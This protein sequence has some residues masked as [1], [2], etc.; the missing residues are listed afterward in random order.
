[1]L[2]SDNFLF[3]TITLKN[4]P[5]PSVTK[6]KLISYLSKW[7]FNGEEKFLNLKFFSTFYKS[8]PYA[9]YITLTTIYYHQENITPVFKIFKQVILF[10]SQSKNSNPNL[11]GSKAHWH[12]FIYIMAL[13]SDKTRYVAFYTILVFLKNV[14]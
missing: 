1:M 12:H 3:N 11:S 8:K 5:N 7:I 4:L 2:S 10:R 14:H 9:I 13:F 6:F